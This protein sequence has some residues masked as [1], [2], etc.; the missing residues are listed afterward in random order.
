MDKF[1]DELHRQL[2]R[3]LA[4]QLWFQFIE[5][6]DEELWLLMRSQ[7]SGLLR[8]RLD[9]QLTVGLREKYDG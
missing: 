7:F 8:E 2:D 3:K 5:I 9:E 1:N 4:D 6:T